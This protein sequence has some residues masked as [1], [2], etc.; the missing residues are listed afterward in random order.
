MNP[1]LSM[2]KK[3]DCDE[4]S[5]YPANG[6]LHRLQFLLSGVRSAGAIWI[7]F[8]GSSRH[9]HGSINRGASDV[10]AGKDWSENHSLV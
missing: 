6:T 3:K 8:R 9:S 7:V 5:N 4:N 1:T 10:D 2:E